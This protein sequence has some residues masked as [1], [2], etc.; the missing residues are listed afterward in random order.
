MKKHDEVRLLLPAQAEMLDVLREPRILDAAAIVKGEDALERLLAAVVHIRPAPVHVPQRRRLERPL[1]GL[2]LRDGVSAEV[3]RRLVHPDA[4]VA[5]ALVGE[6]EPGMAPHAPRLAL[7]Q[8]EAPLRALRER[9]FVARLKTIV[10]GAARDYCPNVGGDCLGDAIGV[11]VGPEHL[12]KLSLI[13]RNGS[14]VLY[15][16]LVGSVA[17]L[18]RLLLERGP[19]ASP[20]LPIAEEAVDKGRRM[21]RRRLAGKG[22][23]EL[24]RIAPAVVGRMAADTGHG[25]VGGPALVPEELLPEG[26]LL[27]RRRIVVR[28]IG[29]IRIETKR[30]LRLELRSDAAGAQQCDAGEE[31]RGAPPFHASTS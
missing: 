3:R 25:A 23:R 28:S 20:Q 30:E 4:D 19:E 12:A 11:E 7:E 31:Q 10:W 6:V 2:V 14:E 24:S 17:V 9:G 27:R 29:G 16:H 5:V 21:T 18:Q 8:R 13:R 26:D 22:D 15:H 1:V